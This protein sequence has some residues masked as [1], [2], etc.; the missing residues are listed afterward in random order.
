M[1]KSKDKPKKTVPKTPKPQIFKS[2]NDYDP[3]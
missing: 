1:A 3:S 2:H